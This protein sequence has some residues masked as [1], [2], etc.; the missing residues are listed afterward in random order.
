MT[1][2]CRQSTRR[3]TNP[4]R[5]RPSRSRPRIPRSCSSPYLTG[6]VKLNSADLELTLDG[7]VTQIIGLRFPG[8]AIPQGATIV[9]A[10][11]Q[12]TADEVRTGPIALTLHGEAADHS[13]PF[14]GT[15]FGVSG[16]PPTTASV[17]WSPPDWTT[18]GAAGEAERTPDLSAVVQEIVDRP[19]WTSG[20]ALVLVVSGTGHRTAESFEGLPGGAAA[21]RVEVRIEAPG[22]P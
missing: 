10:S 9:S 20:N 6:A 22:P 13:A 2:R 8:V 14:D 17:A 12:F 4:C 5:A 16:R 15:A 21:L 18:V 11:V 3:E 7:S 1:S 19:G